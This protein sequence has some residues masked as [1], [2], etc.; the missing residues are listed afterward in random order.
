MK[1]L[2]QRVTGAS[3]SVLNKV[4]GEIGT[5]LVIFVAVGTDD[6]EKDADFLVSKIIGLRIFPHGNSAFDISISDIE[7]DILVVSQFTL[8]ANLRKG[9]RPSFI[10]A[11]TPD[12]AEHLYNYFVDRIRST[13]LKTATGV[14]QEHMVVHIENDGPFT[15]WV[16]SN[17]SAISRKSK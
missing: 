9:R 1:A 14:F 16:D 6:S 11:A 8:M 15:L 7:G 3:V 5:G 4:V 13:G 17:L 2:I 12:K 10:D